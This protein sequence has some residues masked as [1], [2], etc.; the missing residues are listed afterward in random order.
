MVELSEKERPTE[1]YCN[2]AH[3]KQNEK[4]YRPNVE[5]EETDFRPEKYS[6]KEKIQWVDSATN[7][8]EQ[9]KESQ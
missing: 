7:W 4:I 6:N 1:N 2:E 9:R 8:R 3:L 5:P